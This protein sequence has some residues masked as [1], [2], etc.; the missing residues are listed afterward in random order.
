MLST[1]RTVMNNGIGVGEWIDG[2]EWVVGMDARMQKNKN[3]QIFL[4]EFMHVP[5][6]IHP[7][8]SSKNYGAIFL[9]HW[10]ETCV[11]YLDDVNIYTHV[12]GIHKISLSH[13]SL[14]ENNKKKQ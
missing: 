7:L 11:N 4:N 2:W 3:Q 10:N 1:T 13:A 12:V 5:P 6:P 14:T 9:L 8:L